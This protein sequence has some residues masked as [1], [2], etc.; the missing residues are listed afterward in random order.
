MKIEIVKMG[1]GLALACEGK[2]LPAQIK[3]EYH[4]RPFDIPEFIVTFAVDGEMLK[5]PEGFEQ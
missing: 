2:L 5:L 4:T 1:E 3:T